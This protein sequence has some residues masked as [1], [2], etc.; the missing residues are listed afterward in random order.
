MKPQFRWRLIPARPSDVVNW[1]AGEVKSVEDLGSPRI[2]GPRSDLKCECGRTAGA[3]FAGLFCPF[4]RTYIVTDA[5]RERRMSMGHIEL[6]VECRNPLTNGADAEENAARAYIASFPVAPL[7]VR[8]AEGGA[9]TVLG[10]RYEDLVRLNTHV[11]ERWAASHPC[12]RRRAEGDV[13][14]ETELLTAILQIIGLSFVNGRAEP[15]AG[16]TDCLSG[17]LIR[18]ILTHDEQAMV[19]ARCCLLSL[20][21]EARL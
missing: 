7:S 19:I 14:G 10:R 5:A 1:S 11:R 9:T 13:E 2:F 16:Q 18:N 3:S 12:E 8:V 4:C 15:L 17:L 21:V 6:A 20:D